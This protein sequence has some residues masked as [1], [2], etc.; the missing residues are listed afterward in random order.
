[1]GV[2]VKIGQPQNG[3]PDRFKWKQVDY[4]LRSNSWWPLILVLRRWL[5]AGV[6]GLEL[7]T[8]NTCLTMLASLTCSLRRGKLQEDTC[9]STGSVAWQA[10]GKAKATATP[11]SAYVDKLV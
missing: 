10:C 8:Q 1:M 7:S 11:G 3:V 2:V 4:T 6:R 5:R 9:S